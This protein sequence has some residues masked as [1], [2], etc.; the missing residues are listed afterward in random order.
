M[1]RSPDTPGPVSL[2]L[3]DLAGHPVMT[4]MDGPREAGTQ[5]VSFDVSRLAAGVYFYRLN[6]DGH[7]QSRHLAIVH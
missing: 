1:A 5:S 3:Y 4:L 6:A 2:R 7:T